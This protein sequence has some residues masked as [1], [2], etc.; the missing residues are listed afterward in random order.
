MSVARQRLAD[1]GAG[2]R[3]VLAPAAALAV[4]LDAM[5]IAILIEFQD[6]G[7]ISNSELAFRVGISPPQCSQRLRALRDQGVI[8]GAR[9]IVD[10]KL[11][12]YELVL[13]AMIQLH[14][15]AQ[16]QLNEFERFVNGQMNVRQSWLLSGDIDYLLKFVARDFTDILQFISTLTAV[17]NVRGIRTSLVLRNVIDAAVIPLRGRFERD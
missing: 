2:N 1:K 5:D 6:N 4:E 3:G 9:A 14:S 15:Q 7:R 8:K 17:P 11:L 16:R 10:P 12:N 13:L